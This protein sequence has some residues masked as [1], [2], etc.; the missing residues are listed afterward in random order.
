MWNMQVE[1]IKTGSVLRS[2]REREGALAVM[3]RSENIYV[4]SISLGTLFSA[5]MHLTKSMLTNLGV[6][7]SASTAVSNYLS[8]DFNQQAVRF[9]SVNLGSVG[10]ATSK[11]L[12]NRVSTPFEAKLRASDNDPKYTWGVSTAKENQFDFSPYATTQHTAQYLGFWIYSPRSLVD[13]LAEPDMPKMDIHIDGVES[14]VYLNG[15]RH[16]VE[17]GVF[18]NVPIDKGWNYMIVKFIQSPGEK[19][20]LSIGISSDSEAYMQQIETVLIR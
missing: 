7:F 4:N 11:E 16:T 19:S 17:S 6:D 14:L 10:R 1:G 9:L 18:K 15:N 13:L 5:K 12:L 20:K 8:K 2:E 3:L